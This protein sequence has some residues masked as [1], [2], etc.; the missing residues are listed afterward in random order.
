MKQPSKFAESIAK[1]SFRMPQMQQSW[2]AHMQVFG[3]I[4]T[5]AYPDCWTARVHLTNILNKISR[6]DV[7]GAKATMQTL[8]QSCGCDGDA[9]KALWHFLEGLCGEVSGDENAM[10]DGYMAAENYHHRFYLPHVKLAKGAHAASEFDIACH[11]YS[12]AIRCIR[13]M[14]DSPAKDKHLASALTN[15]ASCLTSMHRY[16]DALAAMEEARRTM[17]LPGMEVTQAI[18]LAAMDRE[19]E[20]EACLV[21][22]A[23]A[24]SPVYD[25]TLDMVE[26]IMYGDDPHFHVVPADESAFPAFWQW[27]AD[28]ESHLRQLLRQEESEALEAQLVSQL[29]PCFPFEHPALQVHPG[30]DCEEPE[31]YV[32]DFYSRSLQ[33]G[34]EALLTACPAELAARWTFTIEH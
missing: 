8:L 25:Q 28:N 34:Y 10:V 22:L 14:P 16:D 12:M 21:A 3:P 31:L 7:P 6:R 33:A 30:P 9:E 17:P 11:E 27:F 32:L 24:N 15:L 5:P 23:E 2:N 18:L 4:L 13:E 20:M 26:R 19:E 1:A 29:S